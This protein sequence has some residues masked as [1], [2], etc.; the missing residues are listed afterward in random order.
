MVY[1]QQDE[2][3]SAEENLT[4]DKRSL[5]QVLVV[6]LPGVVVLAGFAD[7]SKPAIANVR[8]F[9]LRVAGDVSQ[10]FLASGTHRPCRDHHHILTSAGPAPACYES[11]AGFD[12]D[13]G[14]VDGFGV[15]FA[16]DVFERDGKR[17]RNGVGI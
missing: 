5:D 15:Q 9:L 6:H 14:D 1:V 16:R 13:Q 7:R 2:G 8:K 17:R 10:R 4:L 11:S 12:D 3:F